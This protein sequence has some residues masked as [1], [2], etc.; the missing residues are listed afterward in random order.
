MYRWNVV[1]FRGEND[2]HDSE[3]EEDRVEKIKEI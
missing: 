1:E 2:R 3:R